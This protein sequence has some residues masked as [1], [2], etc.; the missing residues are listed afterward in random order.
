MR[1]TAF[2]A[3]VILTP[4]VQAQQTP[5]L[6]PPPASG[7]R[8]S[9]VTLQSD[10]EVGEGEIV[11][12]SA[13]LVSVPVSVIDRQGK[14]VVD[15]QQ[16]DFSIYEDGVEQSITH[17][18]NIDQPFSV[19][20]LMDTSDSTA[21][22]LAQMK[23]AARSFV[24]QLRS[25][26]KVQPVS[27]HGVVRPLTANSIGDRNLLNAAIDRMSP[28]PGDLGTRL[29]DAVELA[30]NV[31]KPVSGRK[32]I[33]LFT[34]GENT[35]GKATM[36]S[37]LH[38]AEESDAIIYTLQYGSPP[39]QKYLQQLAEKT[40]GR[41]FMTPD[42]NTISR[43][44]AQVAEELRQQYVLGYHPNEVAQEGQ[45]RRIRVR[46]DRPRVAVRARRS[47]TYKPYGNE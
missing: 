5:R 37:T 32:A 13:T 43:S 9:P 4:L 34:D 47:Y 19:V 44:L 28:G 1:K 23:D 11:R 35:W 8:K 36:K 18:S 10:E 46:V 22:F 16:R 17:F 12:V 31:L 6:Q 25:L 3:L 45:E 15:L 29:Y 30:L 33:I 7:E 21:S 41:Y 20:L 42:V 27:F 14:Y 40:G 26:D 39:A 2:L 24:A 38:Q